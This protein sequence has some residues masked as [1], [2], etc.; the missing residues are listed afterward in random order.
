MPAITTKLLALGT[1]P[2]SAAVILTGI[3][4]ANFTFSVVFSDASGLSHPGYVADNT[5]GSF[6]SLTLS[7]LSGLKGSILKA[8]FDLQLLEI[9]ESNP[10]LNSKQVLSTLLAAYANVLIPM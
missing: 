10:Q 9:A 5:I 1:L 8:A 2:Y 7:D 6:Q 4:A 3:T